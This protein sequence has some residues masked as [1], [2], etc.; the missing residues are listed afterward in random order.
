MDK[1]IQATTVERPAPKVAESAIASSGVDRRDVQQQNSAASILET[2]TNQ[3]AIQPEIKLENPTQAQRA[4]ILHALAPEVLAAVGLSPQESNPKN[5]NLLLLCAD[6][7]MRSALRS[8]VVESAQAE[9]AA[10]EERYGITGADKA[11]GNALGLGV[12]GALLYVQCGRN[13]EEAKRIAELFDRPLPPQAMEVYLTLK[14]QQEGGPD[15]GVADKLQNLREQLDVVLNQKGGVER[16]IASGEK[17]L[18]EYSSWIKPWNWGLE[19]DIE[20]GLK[21]DKNLLEEYKVKEVE[22]KTQIEKLT[23]QHEQLQIQDQKVRQLALRGQMQ[24]AMNLAVENEKSHLALIAAID[25]ARGQAHPDFSRWM[26]EN[27][28]VRKGLQE[29]ID[30]L[31]T[32]ITVTKYTQTAINVAAGATVMVVTGGTIGV[33]AVGGYVLLANVP[34]LAVKG[35][36]HYQ[37]GE[38]G[39]DLALGIGKDTLQVFAEAAG[40]AAGA[41]LVMR[42]VLGNSWWVVP[43]G[44]GVALPGQ[45]GGATQFIKLTGAD[46]V[47]IQLVTHRILPA[48][49]GGG[50]AV[51]E[52]TYRSTSSGTREKEESAQPTPEELA[53]LWALQ[54]QPAIIDQQERGRDNRPIE[55]PQ[56]LAAPAAQLEEMPLQLQHVPQ[57]TQPDIPQQAIVAARGVEPSQHHSQPSHA[58][59]ASAPQGPP[60]DKP[61]DAPQAPR[62]EAALSS[63]PPPGFPDGRPPELPPAAIGAVD[64]NPQPPSPPDNRPMIPP[65]APSTDVTRVDQ[66]GTHHQ[67]VPPVVAHLPEGTVVAPRQGIEGQPINIP[68]HQQSVGESLRNQQH[69]SVPIEQT[70]QV[71]QLNRQMTP[72]INQ[73]AQAYSVSH[74][75]HSNPQHNLQA[76]GNELANARENELRNAEQVRQQALHAERLR[77]EEEAFHHK[78]LLEQRRLLDEKR[79]REEAAALNPHVQRRA[80]EVAYVSEQQAVALKHSEHTSGQLEERSLAR[81]AAYEQGVRSHGISNSAAASTSAAVAYAEAP[82]FSIVHQSAVTQAAVAQ[83][84]SGGGRVGIHAQQAGTISSLSLEPHLASTVTVAAMSETGRIRAAAL[85]RSGAP[86]NDFILNTT[87]AQPMAV[88]PLVAAASSNSRS[89]HDGIALSVAQVS[90]QA[91]LQGMALRE[92]DRRAE[93]LLSNVLATPNS[94][95]VTGKASTAAAVSLASTGA[96]QQSMAQ[97]TQLLGDTV[98]DRAAEQATTPDSESR[99][100]A[101]RRAASLR[102]KERLKRRA[103]IDALK[104]AAMEER[105]ARLRALRLEQLQT[106]QLL[107]VNEVAEGDAGQAAPTPPDTEAAKGTDRTAPA[108][109]RTTRAARYRKAISNR[110]KVPVGGA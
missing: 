95:V 2:P 70:R 51:A 1:K 106:D 8:K 103:A 65:I 4:E 53:R 81:V 69:V 98:R 107:L 67:G 57:Q 79:Q 23:A 37:D 45:W 61:S 42:L 17:K 101:R 92:A 11:M 32:A 66:Q 16:N 10:L 83:Q 97:R 50:L 86:N 47:P 88:G 34:A 14:A 104:R 91:V 26:Q 96:V 5:L 38:R 59:G 73:H 24:E 3:A 99:N 33:F 54:R 56:A 58:H 48:I 13:L 77:Y 18:E 110:A 64:S 84:S 55:H 82:L 100:D 78:Q 108:G 93:D 44:G 40:G 76:V 71:E 63:A 36:T 49:L 109:V 25:T 41:S 90:T 85:E 46:A 80:A 62:A 35:Y 60:V 30:N 7:E 74:L 9:A 94:R 52:G 21:N 75:Q 89:Q 87:V 29:T 43:Q 105:L 27:E 72:E 19:D 68:A 6:Q 12:Y 15:G 31:G 102:L 20:A 28:N 22:L 39:L